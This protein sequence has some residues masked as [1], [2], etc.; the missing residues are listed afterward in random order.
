[1]RVKYRISNG[2]PLILTTLCTHLQTTK[3]EQFYCCCSFV[4]KNKYHF[5]WLKSAISLVS[6]VCSVPVGWGDEGKGNINELFLSFFFSRYTPVL[7][8]LMHWVCFFHSQNTNMVLFGKYMPDSLRNII[9]KRSLLN[10]PALQGASVNK[11][12]SK[13]L[14]KGMNPNY[15]CFVN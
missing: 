1:M 7:Y 14:D 8:T 2:Y 3:S 9:L 5:S 12:Q 6:P 10:Y 15:L 4:I 11:N 13:F